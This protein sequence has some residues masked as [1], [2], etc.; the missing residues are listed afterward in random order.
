V[1]LAGKAAL[2]TGGAAGI[3]RAV[4]ERLVG[5]GAAVAIADRDE[6]AGRAAAADLCATFVHA[7]VATD[8]DVRLALV[9]AT[10]RLGGLD[11]LVN[12]A[13]GIEP[14]Y[15]PDAPVEH[16]SYALDLNLRAVMLATQLAIESM[17]ARGGGAIV[18]IA[19]AAGLGLTA[20]EAPEYSAAKAGVVRLTATLAPLA[21]RLGIRV[22]C[23]CPHLV[24]TPA[25]RRERAGMTPAEITALPAAMAPAEI[26]AA[27]AELVTDDQ[28][29]GRV[30]VCRAG[31]P[32]RLL[33]VTA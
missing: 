10:A 7:D 1:R 20:H 24:D 22:N 25:A 2:V 32:H 21:E 5:G 12:N 16:W 4:V 8:G 27:V 33:P 11:I 14:P 18:N 28:L 15:Y 19:S 23:V 3:G 31:E 30:M 13:G 26:A 6:T 9:A 17:A 29:A